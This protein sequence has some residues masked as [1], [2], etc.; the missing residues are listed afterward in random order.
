M[1]ESKKITVGVL[2]LGFVGFVMSLVLANSRKK[3]NVI[4]FD[5]DPQLVKKN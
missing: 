5:I 2:G 3:Y 1:D 4:G